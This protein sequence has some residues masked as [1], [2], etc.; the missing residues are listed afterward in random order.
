MSKGTYMVFMRGTPMYPT[1]QGSMH[2]MRLF[3]ENYPWI[4]RN[5]RKPN[6]ELEYFDLAKDEKIRFELLRFAKFSEVPQFYV[7]GQ[8]VGGYEMIVE[9]HQNNILTNI[10]LGNGKRIHPDKYD[11]MDAKKKKHKY[12]EAIVD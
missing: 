7:D 5:V 4:L 3:R 10:L 8:L 11:E 12:Q 2:L 6:L 9:M 1:C